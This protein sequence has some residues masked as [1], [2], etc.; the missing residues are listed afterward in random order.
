LQQEFS[1]TAIG[2]FAKEKPMRATEAEEGDRTISEQRHI[3]SGMY[4]TSL[5]KVSAG[6]YCYIL[7]EK[8][9]YAVNGDATDPYGDK[10]RI[11]IEIVDNVTQD[12]ASKFP[13]API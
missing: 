5:S 9:L 8:K 10:Q 13:G 6:L 1:L 12:I 7:S 2:L 3:L 4:T 11:Q